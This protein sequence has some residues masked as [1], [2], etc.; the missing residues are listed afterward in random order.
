VAILAAGREERVPVRD[1]V[2]QVPSDW[3]MEIA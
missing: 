1:T 2:S 3:T